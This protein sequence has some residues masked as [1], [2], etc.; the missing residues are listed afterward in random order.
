MVAMDAN[1]LL[2]TRREGKVDIEKTA[3]VFYNP[4]QVIN[5]D[6]SILAIQAFHNITKH[7]HTGDEPYLGFT[8]VEPLAA[9]GLRSLRYLAELDCVRHVVAGD[10]DPNAVAKIRTNA[11][12]NSV[13]TETSITLHCREASELLYSLKNQAL[14][15]IGQSVCGFKLPDKIEQNILTTINWNPLQQQQ[16]QGRSPEV[17]S[18]YNR[19]VD[20]IDLDPYG[21]VAPFIDAAVQSVRSGGL[22]CLTSTD[23]MVLCG[24]SPE[25]A[26]YKY[27]CFSTKARYTHEF[28]LRLVLNAVIMSAARHRRAVVPLACCSIDFYVRLF[29]QIVDSPE[30]CK[31]TTTNSAM[32]FQCSS[33]DS[34]HTVPLGLDGS[35]VMNAKSENQDKCCVFTYEGMATSSSSIAAGEASKPDEQGTNEQGTGERLTGKRKREGS[36]P[37]YRAGLLPEDMSALCDQCGSR[38]R[39]FGPIYAGPLFSPKFV[40]EGLALCDNENLLSGLTMRPKIRGLFSAMQEELLDV[41]LFYTIPSLCSRAKLTMMK[42]RLFKNALRNLGYRVSHFHREPQA[43]KTDAPNHVVFDILREHAKLTASSDKTDV[44]KAASR[45]QNIS[46]SDPPSSSP[47]ARGPPRWLPN[48]TADWG[49]KAKARRITPEDVVDNSLEPLAD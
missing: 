46:F 24:T 14:R 5:R 9:T 11:K 21:S 35:K 41:P 47:D 45:T 43:I 48:P 31:R 37:S 44:L 40:E 22:L 25:V 38:F 30:S 1:P 4:A 7:K 8:V 12:V 3:N 36:Q 10:L 49:P 18:L 15:R 19:L 27:G 42:P 2:N 13:D 16:Q 32:V 17:T 6:L 26:F 20:I 23:M 33:C 28:S 34:F 29:L 39:M